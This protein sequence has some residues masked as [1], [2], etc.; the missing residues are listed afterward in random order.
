MAAGKHALYAYTNNAQTSGNSQLLRLEND[1]ASTTNATAYFKND[2]TGWNLFLNQPGVNA[3]GKHNLYVYSNAIQANA[4][5]CVMKLD[6]ASSTVNVLDLVNDGLGTC[7]TAT[8]N[9]NNN[10]IF[11]YQHGTASTPWGGRVWFTAAAPDNNTQYFWYGRD[12][13]TVRCYIWSDGD[14]ANHD[15][16]YGTISDVKFKENIEDVRSYWDDFKSLRYRKWQD[17][18]DIKAYG[19]GAP[20][21]L[22]LVAQ[23]VEGIFPS[24]VPISNDEVNG[25]IFKWVKSSIIDGMINSIVLQEA[26]NRIETNEISIQT[27]KTLAE[28]NENRI[29]ELEA[30]V[31]DLET[32]CAA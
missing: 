25:G 30:Q 17:K 10:F 15:G 21:R 24:L 6:H 16:S 13:S 23:E 8:Q 14:L 28:A 31:A 20:F 19:A 32:R 2:G 9:G 27:V 26:Q 11:D 3:S 1:H 29:I 7:F 12:S 18:T 5:M 4:S 22:G